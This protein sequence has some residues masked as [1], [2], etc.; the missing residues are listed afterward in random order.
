MGIESKLAVEGAEE[1]HREDC[2]RLIARAAA[3]LVAAGDMGR[4]KAVQAATE[5]VR[6][7]SEAEGD[8]TGVIAVENKFPTPSKEVDSKQIA[9]IEHKLMD[10]ARAAADTL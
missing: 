3:P 9:A 10:A 5:W 6:R 4:V 1:Q 8:V 2:A 7:E